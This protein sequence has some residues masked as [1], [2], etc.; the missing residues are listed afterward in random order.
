[1]DERAKL[2]WCMFFSAVKGWQYHPGVKQG[3][4]TKE[5]AEIADAML[6]EYKEREDQSWDGWQPRK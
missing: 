4:T 3:L 5:C 1:M 6:D 2:A